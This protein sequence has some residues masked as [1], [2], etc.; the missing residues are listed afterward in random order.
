[1]AKR[2]TI[3]FVDDDPSLRVILP[4]LLPQ[5]EFRSLVAA[6]GTEA[7]GI[8]AVQPVD[9]LVTDLVM[10]GMLGLELAWDAKQRW[11]DLRVV[12]M[13]GHYLQGIQAE[14]VGPVLFKPIRPRQIES[15]IR[16]YLP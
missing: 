11:P 1:M 2:F 5:D 12:F 9:M 4:E 7:M 15:V 3:L 10:D 6:N 16:Q 14:N 8:L 13:T